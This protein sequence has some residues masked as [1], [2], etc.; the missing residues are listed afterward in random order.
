MST[1]IAADATPLVA[2]DICPPAPPSI[3]RKSAPTPTV[4]ELPWGVWKAPPR[5][6]RNITEEARIGSEDG[7]KIHLTVDFD[8]EGKPCAVVAVVHKEG[9]VFRG[10]LDAMAAGASQSLQHGASV[11]EVANRYIGV[12]FE[13]SGPVYEHDTIKECLSVVDLFGQM[14]AQF[15]SID[16]ARPNN[17]EKDHA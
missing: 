16:A 11:A 2:I 5:R 12:R 3:M 6:R 14:L 9:A 15:E 1:R 4:T 13:P 7:H 8:N 10:M 17:R